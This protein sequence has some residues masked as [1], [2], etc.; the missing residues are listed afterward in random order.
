M[1]FRKRAFIRIFCMDSNAIAKLAGVS[2]STVS[3]VVN[4]Y[5]NVPPGTRA[6]VMAVIERYGYEPNRSARN[7]AGKPNR[8]IGLFIVDMD[9]K[10]TNVV[11]S[12]PFFSEFLIHVADKLQ[13]RGY[14]LLVSLVRSDE[15]LN[16]ISGMVAGQTVSGAIIMGDTLSTQF[17]KGLSDGGGFHLLI[18]QRNDTEL[19][20][21]LLLNTQNYQGARAAVTFLIEHGHRRI[22]HIGGPLEKDSTRDR[23]Q[24]YRDS[25]LAHDLP[26]DERHVALNKNIHRAESGYASARAIFGPAEDR[27][28]AVFCSNDLMALGAMKALSD[29]NLRVPADVSVIGYDNIEIGRHASPALS[30]VSTSVETMAEMAADGLYDCIEKG[31]LGPR[32]LVLEKFEIIVRESVAAAN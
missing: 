10:H 1:L 4:G 11:Q 23:Y 22:A 25:L 32:K 7:L 8:T 24:G 3:R 21:I 30:T 27:P 18:N 15:Q 6:K 20:N 19:P 17:L 16:G 28:T 5:A 13:G 29:L 12:S 9:S 26:L 2:R 14:Q 31:G